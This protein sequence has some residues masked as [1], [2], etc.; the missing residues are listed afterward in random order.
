LSKLI[1]PAKPYFPVEDVEEIKGHAEKIST[2]GMLTLHTCTREFE[3]MFS[4]THEVKHSVAVSSGTV[5][6]EIALRY[7]KGSFNERL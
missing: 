5:A 1:P 7:Q 4:Q 6:L 3:E 2:P